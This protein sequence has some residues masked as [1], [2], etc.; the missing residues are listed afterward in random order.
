[1]KSTILPI[2]IPSDLSATFFYALPAACICGDPDYADWY[3]MNYLDFYGYKNTLNP[4]KYEFRFV[5]AVSYVDRGLHVNDAVSV[6]H[7]DLTFF[8]CSDLIGFLKKRID[9]R[10]YIILYVDESMI[11]GSPFASTGHEYLVYGYDDGTEE[12]FMLGMNSRQKYSEMKL[13]YDVVK[14]AFESLIQNYDRGKNIYQLGITNR[15]TSLAN[16][17]NRYFSHHIVREYREDVFVNKIRA[18]VDG[19]ITEGSVRIINETINPIISCGA[20]TSDVL[21]LYFSEV[22]SGENEFE[23][24]VPFFF[25][26]HKRCVCNRINYA[27]E[28]TGREVYKAIAEEYREV[29]S[30]FELIKNLHIKKFVRSDLDMSTLKDLTDR[31][32]ETERRILSKI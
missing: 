31:A 6:D 1:M 24:N 18:Y 16:G 23:F 8:S 17:E 29:V 2:K 3:H 15:Y 4:A 9:A 30:L 28:K 20:K 5:D 26:D 12:L 32:A 14:A 25:L 21:R 19:R 13:G 7:Y 11:P 22:E 27:F 10:Y